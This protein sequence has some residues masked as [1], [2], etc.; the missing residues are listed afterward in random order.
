MPR[1]LPGALV[2][3]LSLIVVLGAWEVAARTGHLNPVL[4]PAPSVIAAA[5]LGLVVRGEIATPLA[6]TLLLFAGGYLIACGTGVLV[7]TVMG[8]NRA[9]YTT[10]EPLVELVRPLPKSALTPILYLFLG[11]GPA[12]M[13]T[14]VALGAFFPVALNTL[15]GVRGI[16]PVLTETARTFGCSRLRTAFAVVLPAAA[17]MILA[18]MRT[19]L[20]LGLVLIILAEMLV[21]E[22]GL[23]FLIIDLQRSFQV[24]DM[25]AWIVVLAVVGGILTLAFD[26]LDRHLVP[27]RG[28]A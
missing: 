13:I 24:R 26:T 11:S 10:L 15:A 28:R 5:L 12:L 4:I 7:G 1:A 19:A 23:G 9:V 27:W 20:G 21:G 22:D 17:P 6:H 8:V 18:G 25:Y 3:A 14:I 2:S 16:D